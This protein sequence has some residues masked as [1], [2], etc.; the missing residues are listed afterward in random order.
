MSES[1]RRPLA[2][3]AVWRGTELAA[4]GDWS[5]PLTADEIEDID[6]ALGAVR[7][8]GLAWRDVRRQDFPLTGF[9]ERLA[10][11]AHELE[12]GR[13]MVR[14]RGLPA[15]RYSEA[16][17]R[18]IFW[19]VGTHLGTAVYQ[20]ASGEILGEVRDEVRALGAVREA[21]GVYGDGSLPKSS[22]AKA[23]SNALLRF[24]TDR[25]DVIGLLC[26]R[27]AKAGGISRM[28]S[29][30]ALHNEILARR[31]DLHAVLCGDYW[32]SRQ[33]EEANGA[34]RAYA[35][36]VFAVRDGH[37][38]SH[39]SRTFIE[40]AEHVPGVPR[41]SAAQVEAM[42][43]IAEVA[44]ELCLEAPFEPGDLQFLNNH[45]VYHA[46]SAYADDGA[47]GCDRLLFRLWLAMPNSRPLPEGHEI[48]WGSTE[49]GA[50]RGGIKQPT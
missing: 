47:P 9:A 40:A 33:G 8:R 2:G 48:L 34:T 3:P 43:L 4:S 11:V 37:F 39:Y 10:A 44:D 29:A 30:V 15:D 23:R 41:L 5:W 12:H 42:D 50:L 17:L 18:H 22:R 46:R 25:A 31:P 27:P 38:T 21:A 35:L 24:H 7:K 26:V 13:G 16:D 32:R 19:G 28:V 45:V 36:P 20:N 1:L 49:P 6:A 14:L